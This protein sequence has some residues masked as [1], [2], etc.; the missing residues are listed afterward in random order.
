MAPSAILAAKRVIFGPDAATTTGAGQKRSSHGMPPRTPFWN[1]T[2]SLRSS[3]FKSTTNLSSSVA[4][5]AGMPIVRNELKPVPTP[6]RTRPGYISSSVAIA[7][8]VALT[9]RVSG[10]VTPVASEMREVARQARRESHED[11]PANQLGVDHPNTFKSKPLCEL[12]LLDQLR[13]RLRA[14]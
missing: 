5:A 13:D 11:V 2:L 7:L 12:D 10:L 6:A 9:W 14:P 4:L 8:A 1:A 3:A